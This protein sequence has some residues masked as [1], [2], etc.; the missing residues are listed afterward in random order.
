MAP[1]APHMP[2]SARPRS[3]V[4]I[5]GPNTGKSHF[6]Y[7]VYGRLL[8]PGGALRLRRL[9]D[10]VNLFKDGLQ[11]LH[12]GLAARHTATDQYLEGS[13]PLVGSND[14]PVD[15]VWPDYG[16]EQLTQQL[17]SRRLES[18][19]QARLSSADGW[20]LFLRLELIRPLKDIVA[21][22]L[23]VELARA[24]SADQDVPDLSGQAKTVELLQMLLYAA[25]ADVSSPLS[26]PA[27]GVIL[28]CW[29]EVGVPLGA[30]PQSVLGERAPLV[31]QFIC[32]NWRPDRH[33]VVGL[34]SIERELNE[35]VP[36]E[37]FVK[38]GPEHFGFVV[39]PD[40]SQTADL[41]LPVSSLLS[42]I[43]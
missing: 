24:G 2:A 9:P 28:S 34:S 6:A 22:P 38:K 3:F 17:S 26:A 5:G 29:D 20:L 13:L 40:G 1:N 4:I 25:G 37:M 35:T 33:F 43:S 12:R 31:A 14:T 39:R 32:S 7:Q 21:N 42:L 41:T 15:I 11:R 16:G 10:N 36:D 27:L 18:Q 30:E 23:E 19:W 8:S